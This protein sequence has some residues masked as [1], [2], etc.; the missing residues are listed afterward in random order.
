MFRALDA[1]DSNAAFLDDPETMLDVLGLQNLQETL[2]DLQNMRLILGLQSKHDEPRI[3]GRWAGSNV[4]K[5][6]VER[7]KRSALALTNGGEL[8][9]LG[10]T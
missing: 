7:D 1:P 2:A 3:L 4:G 5:A 6:E 9:I 8:V 10:A